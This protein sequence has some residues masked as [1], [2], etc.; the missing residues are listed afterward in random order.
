[1]RFIFLI[2]HLSTWVGK[3]F[4]WAILVL[5]FVVSYEVFMR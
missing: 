3:V 5:T 2:D 4:A 1:M